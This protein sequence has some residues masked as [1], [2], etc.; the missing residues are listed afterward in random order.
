MAKP[1]RA[2]EL[3]YPVH[4]VFNNFYFIDMFANIIALYSPLSKLN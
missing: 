4:S 3:H 1:I 2:L